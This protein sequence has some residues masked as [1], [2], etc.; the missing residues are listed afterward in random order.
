MVAFWLQNCM[1]R[2]KKGRRVITIDNKI[3]I[4]FV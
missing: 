3:K 1:M 2:A 4:S